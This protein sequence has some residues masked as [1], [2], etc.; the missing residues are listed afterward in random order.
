MPPSATFSRFLNRKRSMQGIDFSAQSDAVSRLQLFN[1]AGM[2][3][4]GQVSSGFG[5]QGVQGRQSVTIDLFDQLLPILA[6][7]GLRLGVTASLTGNLLRESLALIQ[8]YPKAIYAYIPQSPFTPYTPSQTGYVYAPIW[9]TSYPVHL[10]GM[11]GYSGLLT[12][13]AGVNAGAAVPFPSVAD[14]FG[15]D[16]SANA[17][18]SGALTGKFVRL[19][20]AYAGSFCSPSD[21]ALGTQ[22]SVERVVDYL[23]SVLDRKDL[24]REIDDWVKEMVLNWLQVKQPTPGSAPASNSSKNT[25]GIKPRRRDAFL[26]K[27]QKVPWSRISAGVQDALNQYVLSLVN[28]ELQLPVFN[29]LLAGFEAY[30][31][32]SGVLDGLNQL[33][34]KILTLTDQ[35]MSALEKRAALRQI[36]FYIDLLASSNQ[37]INPQVVPGLSAAPQSFF[38]LFSFI[39]EAQGSADAEASVFAEPPKIP[40]TGLTISAFGGVGAMAQAKIDIQRIAFRYQSVLHGGKSPLFFTQDAWLTYRRTQASAAAFAQFELTPLSGERPIGR[41]YSYYSLSYVSTIV[42]WKEPSRG[43][44][45]TPLQRS[46]LRLGMTVAT[47][48]LINYAKNPSAPAGQKLEAAITR[49]LKITPAQCRA[50]L[51][52]SEIAMLDDAQNGF[53]PY[54]FLETAFQYPGNFSLELKPDKAEPKSSGRARMLEDPALTSRLESIRL[55]IRLSDMETNEQPIFKLG[56]PANGPRIDIDFSLLRGAGQEGMFDYHAHWFMNDAYNTNPAWAREAE[57]YGIPPVIFLH[58]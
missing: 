46:G 22:A 25:P 14:E 5:Q 58:Q 28:F 11:E 43:R 47:R 57:E 55:R 54:V 7:P 23:F 15:V 44:A 10:L 50:F 9:E 35:E 36:Q 38:N 30:R 8:R 40:L 4:Q 53:P 32:S 24:K 45:T 41:E 51:A 34:A 18:A 13:G 19:R 49:N 33:R 2:D 6:F 52:A 3:Y 27:L 29:D 17:G 20:G 42:Y 16:V 31:A 12:V 39:A 37:R 21:I 56:F 26:A 48:R 1:L